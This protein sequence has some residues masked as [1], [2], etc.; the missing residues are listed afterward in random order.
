MTKCLHTNM[1]QDCLNDTFS[2]ETLCSQIEREHYQR[3]QT[4][5]IQNLRRFWY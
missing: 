1:T 5:V 4:K 3:C 2:V